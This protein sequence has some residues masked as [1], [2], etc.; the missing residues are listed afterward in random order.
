MYSFKDLRKAALY[1][2]PCQEWRTE[3]TDLSEINSAGLADHRSTSQGPTATGRTQKEL[4]N[5]PPTV[6]VKIDS[7][8]KRKNDTYLLS[9]MNLKI[10]DTIPINTQHV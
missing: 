10:P 2:I 8:A 5:S 7:P 1:T 4:P 6:L 3:L 9:S